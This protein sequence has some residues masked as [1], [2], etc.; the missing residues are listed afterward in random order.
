MSLWGALSAA[1]LEPSKI[2]SDDV[3]A[4]V[5]ARIAQEIEKVFPYNAPMDDFERRNASLVYLVRSTAKLGFS[6]IA[7][8]DA[9]DFVWR[10]ADEVG[11][12]NAEDDQVLVSSHGCLIVYPT[13]R[14]RKM[15]TD[16]YF[17]KSVVVYKAEVEKLST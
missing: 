5:S 10:P 14:R 4:S 6:M 15:E 16:G 1:L 7:N 13:L 2:P 3:V 9:C 12:P 8:S 17:G 11:G